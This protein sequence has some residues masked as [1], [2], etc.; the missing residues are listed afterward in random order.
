MQV[1]RTSV[2][3]GVLSAAVGAPAVLAHDVTV[4]IMDLDRQGFGGRWA[5]YEG[6]SNANLPRWQP[7]APSEV[8]PFNADTW[9]TETDPNQHRGDHT[10]TYIRSGEGINVVGYQRLDLL[11]K[12]DQPDIVAA[13]FTSGELL[14]PVAVPTTVTVYGLLP[15]HPS[16]KW[17]QSIGWN[18]PDF[19]QTPPYPLTWNNAPAVDRE[20]NVGSL[21]DA[22]LWGSGAV[23]G[24]FTVNPG[25]LGFSGVSYSFS[26]GEGSN[27]VNFLNDA[28]YLGDSLATF[29]LVSDTGELLGLR[30]RSAGGATSAKMQLGVDII[31]PKWAH[32]GDGLWLDNNNWIG[33]A[34]T[35]AGNHVATFSDAITAPA[36]ITLDGE[37]GAHTLTF[38]NPNSYTIV[39]SGSLELGQTTSTGPTNVTAWVY[40]LQGEHE[41]HVPVVVRRLPR[42]VVEEGAKLTISD[43]TIGNT[44]TRKQGAGELAV[45]RIFLNTTSVGLIIEEGKLSLIPSGGETPA[46]RVRVLDIAGGENPTATLDITDN[47]FVV[48]PHSGDSHQDTA[49]NTIQA[50]IRAG[51]NGGNW[52]GPGITSSTAAQTSGL[53]VGYIHNAVLGAEAFDGVPVNEFSV[54]IK[55]TYAG[56]ANLSGSVTIADLGILAANWQGTDRHWYHGDFN[57]DGLVN[58]ADLGILAANWQAGASGGG[59]SFAEAMAM[60]DVFD[61]VVI[62]EPG[63]LGVVG[64]GL[65]ALR[66]RRTVRA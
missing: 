60:F 50:Q 7:N 11:P 14:D 40:A 33:K 16:E 44:G 10:R 55:T 38:D 36:T 21:I 65:L 57:Y 28:R 56:D 25:D 13:T 45:N 20:V 19:T 41:V 37:A 32:D 9:A 48:R 54:I 17:I 29:V 66:R 30:S 31:P 42:F 43:L 39:G 35:H 63:A 8:T 22:E 15:G 27:L 26:G 4:F 52:D 2:A 3:A 61:G 49:Q 62:P 58:I 46:S 23:L 5:Q 24:T 12:V 59:M 1:L 47:T 34:A 6:N 18:S 51:Y 53:A 64:L